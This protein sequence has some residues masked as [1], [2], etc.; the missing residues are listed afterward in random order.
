MIRNQIVASVLMGAAVLFSA[1]PA[2]AEEEA[3]AV[4]LRVEQTA[5][6]LGDVTAGKE[7]QAVFVIHNDGEA[8]V[9][10]LR[11]KPS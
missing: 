3:A 4:T 10:I 9:R 2:R 6:D 7:N 11:A 5:V 8:D 1:T